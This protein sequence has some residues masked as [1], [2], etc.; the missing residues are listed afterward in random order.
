MRQVLD[1]VGLLEVIPFDP[2]RSPWDVTLIEGLENGRAAL[3]IRAH[4]A[5]T[6]GLGGIRLLGLLL[7]EPEW[8]RAGVPSEPPRS[9]RPQRCP[10]ASVRQARSP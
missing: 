4:H 2:E 6:D 5:L 9:S 1:L 7:D 8:P 3:Y 10:T